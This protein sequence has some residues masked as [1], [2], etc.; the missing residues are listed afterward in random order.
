MN[1]PV[2]NRPIFSTDDFRLAARKRLPRLLFDIIESGV[3]DESLIRRN[4]S[5]YDRHEFVPRVLVDVR[6]RRLATHLFDQTY[7]APIGIAPTGVAGLFRRGAESMLARAARAANVPFILS[8]A[9]IDEMEAVVALAPER[10]WFQ[11]YPARDAAITKDL[12]SR[13]AAAGV[14][15]LVLTVDTP[16]LPNRERDMRNGF[17]FPPKP[18]LRLALDVLRHP[19]WLADYARNGGLP[20]MKTWARYASD[21]ASTQ[22]VMKFFRE[23]SP[24][25]QS[26]KELDEFRRMWKGQLVVKGVQYPGDAVRAAD[27]GVDGLIVSNHGG[28][29][30]DRGLAAIDA[31]PDIAAAVGHRV[32]VMMD[33][34]IRRGADIAMARCLGAHFVFAGR[35]PLYAVIAAGEEGATHCL[36]LLQRELDGTL[37]LLGCPDAADLGPGHRR[38]SAA[39]A[40]A[41]R[42]N[43]LEP[44]YMKETI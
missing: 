36:R 20:M 23:Q 31:L 10:V 9:C 5:A 21:G 29:A 11:L 24:S 30:L 26:W 19:G 43:T 3:E 15:T 42:V 2:K 25:V 39:P 17:G 7:A 8:G 38:T 22:E 28:K 12:L 37:G 4:I 44:I 35:A 40:P 16:V 34:G 18:T 41:H 32:V 14:S 27:A 13:A 33:G 1:A 6:T